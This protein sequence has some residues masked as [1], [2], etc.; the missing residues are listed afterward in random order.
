[1]KHQSFFLSFIIALLT[2]SSTL[3]T[4]KTPLRQYFK[5]AANKTPETGHGLEGV[6]F[7]YMIN[8]DQRPEKFASCT[9][10]LHPFGIYPYRFSAVNGWELTL[11]TINNIGV[12]YNPKTM[13]GGI[14]GTCYL[15]ENN[16]KPS[17]EPLQITGRNYFCHDMSKGAL[18]CILSH[19]SVL[20]DAYDA[21]YNRIWVMEDDI[22]IIQN[23]HLIT[24][25][26]QKL[27]KLAGKHGWDILFTDKDTKNQL[28]EYVPCRAYAPRPN[29]NPSNTRHFTLHANIGSNFIKIG[30]RYGAYSMILQRPAIKKIL[31][32]FNYYKIFHA[33]DIDFHQ[34]VANLN[35]FTVV[36]D[37]VSTQPK[38][39]TDNARPGYQDKKD[40]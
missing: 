20:Q 34:L 4:A 37:I 35:M 10:Q 22:E 36:D 7:I 5:K 29:F 15:A 33:Y 16:G 14:G 30:A 39:P 13:Q 24:Q 18:G 38:A 8:L 9:A 1:M 40:N 17:Y 12:T 21:G 26:L 31:K 32:V 23:P 3:A 25:A 28:G 2:L 11:E 19:L 6:D 27:D